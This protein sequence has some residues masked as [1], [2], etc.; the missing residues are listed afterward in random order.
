M[1]NL[2]LGVVTFQFVV[3]HLIVAVVAIVGTYLFLRNNK[4][5][6]AVID[7]AVDKFKKVTDL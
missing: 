2:L 6:K 1:K 7:A 4:K 5:K 3:T